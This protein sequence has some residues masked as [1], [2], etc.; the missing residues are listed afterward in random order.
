[1]LIAR[2]GELTRRYVAGERARFVSP[3]AIF[4]FS[5]F[6]MF[7]IVANLPGWHIGDT[8]FLKP[9]FQQSLTESRTKLRADSSKP[10]RRSPSRQGSSPRSAPRRSPTPSGSRD[11]EAD[12]RARAGPQGSP[13]RPARA[14]D[15]GASWT[16]DRST[17]RSDELVRGEVPAREGE[18]G[19]V[20][21]KIKTGAYKFSWAL[22]PLSVPFL[23]L[24]FPFAA[25]FGLYDHAVFATYSLTFMSLLMIVLAVLGAIGVPGRLCSPRSLIPPLH[26]YKQLKGAST[27]W[28]GQCPH[29]AA[30]QPICSVDV[31]VIG[32]W[33]PPS[34]L[35][36]RPATERR[37]RRGQPRDRHAEGRARDV[38]EPDLLAERDR[39]RVA[40]MLA[41]DAELDVGLRRAARARPR[42]RTSSPTPSR[43]SADERVLGVDALLDIG[44]AGSGRRRRG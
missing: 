29:R 36:R 28:S 37:L 3:L 40:A 9:G 17:P 12:R 35:R 43:S 7:A 13:L 34:R 19:A 42:A 32:S 31:P 16:I 1:M 41:A 27:R 2:P 22:I 15:V 26:I 14:A 11:R 10:T 23:W 4:L 39:R 21:Y 33:L 44:A 20:L 8:D 5:V 6:L 25:R 24:L 38:V 30:H 18:P